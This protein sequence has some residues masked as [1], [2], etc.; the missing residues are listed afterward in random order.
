MSSSFL[1]KKPRALE[2]SNEKTLGTPEPFSCVCICD[3]VT[4]GGSLKG[5]DINSE[6]EKNS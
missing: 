2:R 3:F 6:V 5:A 4:L 1:E